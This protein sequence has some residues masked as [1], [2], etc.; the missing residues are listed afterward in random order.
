MGSIIKEITDI[1]TDS[2]LGV[3]SLSA[4][5]IG[6]VLLFL[7]LAEQP[8]KI[9]DNVI[10]LSINKDLKRQIRFISYLVLCFGFSLALPVI[11]NSPQI[12]GGE[13]PTPPGAYTKTCTNISVYSS[14]L[15]AYCQKKDGSYTYTSLGIPKCFRGKVANCDG[16]LKY[17][18]SC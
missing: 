17:G 4:L 10:P 18:S 12:N 1:F 7:G 13:P 16:N 5:S 6:I 3:I 9:C 8:I 15:Y 2:F 14:K 11:V